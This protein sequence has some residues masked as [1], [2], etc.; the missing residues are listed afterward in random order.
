MLTGAASG[1]AAVWLVKMLRFLQGLAWPSFP[2]FLGAVEQSSPLHRVLVCI[3]GGAVVT[4]AALISKRPMA[5]HGTSS[6][7]ESIWIRSGRMQLRRTL[8]RGTVSIIAVAFGAPLGREGALLQLGAAVGSTLGRQLRI[9][10]DQ[11]RLLVA[12]GASAGIAA[13]YNVPIGAA[14]FGL[15]VLLGSFALELFGPIVVACVVA[16][17]ISRVLIS[18]H[19]SYDIPL[20]SLM[21]PKELLLDVA[22]GPVL[23]VAA[24]FYNRTI[25]GFSDWMDRIPRKLFV[26]MPILAMAVVGVSSLALPQLLG[27]GYDTVDQALLGGLTW[28][29][30]L[31]LPLAKMLLTAFTSASGIP[32]GLFTPSLF[33]GA[34]L[35]GAMGHLVQLISPGAA[36][37]GAYALIGMG[38]I[39][40]ATTHA[41]VSAVLIIFE[42]TGNYE[43]ILPLMLTTVIAAAVSRRLEPESLYTAPLRR[44]NIQLPQTQRAFLATAD[45][46]SLLTPGA[47]HVSSS[48]TFQ[49]VVVRLLALP[50]GNDLYVTTPE[51]LLL[52]VIVL[53]ALK[54]HLPDHSLLSMTVAADVMAPPIQPLTVQLSL[55]EVASRFADTDLERL[56]VVD[57]RGRLIG[58]LSKRDILRLGRF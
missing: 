48:T 1:F 51:G 21:Q 12:C 40:A 32:G 37:A 18:D 45:V 46:Q 25:S 7:I 20:H 5:G 10:A 54:G 2:T 39:L 47:D 17:L 23:G 14:L 33:F 34:L 15:E 43:V 38:A 4:V 9:P 8:V 22:V 35:G 19:P 58:T 36:P 57:S 13:A 56:P 26:F 52:G 50:A 44:R 29:M 28:K 3:A 31:I 42:L 16:T 24:A 55:S 6:I 27:N 11:A 53:D 49:E 30:L 41:S